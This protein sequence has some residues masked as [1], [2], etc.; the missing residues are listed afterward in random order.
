MAVPIV[1]VAVAGIAMGVCVMLLSLFVMKG[2]KEEI[3]G[4]LAGFVSDLR[5][6][7]YATVAGDN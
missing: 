7:P 1:R 5:V 6:E 2:F 4:K 3:S